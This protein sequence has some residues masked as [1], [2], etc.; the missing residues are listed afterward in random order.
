[1]TVIRSLSPFCGVFVLEEG[2]PRSK[3]LKEPPERIRLP[4]TAI[5]PI[6]LP[7]AILPATVTERLV[8]PVVIVPTPERLW[9]VRI[10]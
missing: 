4:F 2:I 8:A 7:G 3:M 6:E 10:V 5:V 1:V 9:L